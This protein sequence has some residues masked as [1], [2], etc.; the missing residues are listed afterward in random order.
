MPFFLEIKKLLVIEEEP[1][2]MI[3]KTGRKEMQAKD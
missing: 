3:S 1:G 2:N